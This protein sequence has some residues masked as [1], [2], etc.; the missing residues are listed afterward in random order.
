MKKGA[1]DDLMSADEAWADPVTR[2]H[3]NRLIID[4]QPTCAPPRTA[5]V[6]ANCVLA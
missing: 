4:A 3:G 6:D 2:Y 5:C 1:S